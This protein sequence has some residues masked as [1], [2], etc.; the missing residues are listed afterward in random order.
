MTVMKLRHAAALALVGWY[1]LAPPLYKGEV[2]EK[3]PLKEWTV[4]QSF[5]TVTECSQWLSVLLHKA[6]LDPAT[7]TV[8]K[9]RLLAASCMSSD[10]PRLKR[11]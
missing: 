6:N 9:H 3:A 7:R 5:G 1:L 8:V 11:K 2:D 4:L 10:D